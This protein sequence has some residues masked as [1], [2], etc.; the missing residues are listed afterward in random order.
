MTEYDN[1]PIP[2]LPGIPPAGERILS[3][4]GAQLEGLR[5]FP[6]SAAYSLLV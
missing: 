2:G 4:T 5:L 3:R 6:I 1:E